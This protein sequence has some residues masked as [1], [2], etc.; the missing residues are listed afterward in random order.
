[1]KKIRPH[2]EWMI[3][4]FGLLLMASMNPYSEGTSFCLFDFIGITFCPGEGL[5]HSI[6]FLFRG[7]FSNALEANLFGPLAVL[8]LSSRI[9][10]IWKGLLIKK[11]KL[12][13]SE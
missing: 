12:I 4:F 9:L 7:E 3:F 10:S 2:I 1:M 13:L 11:D 6:A 5:G 8:V